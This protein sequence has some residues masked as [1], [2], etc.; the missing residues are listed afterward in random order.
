MLKS[1]E[2][3]VNINVLFGGF[4]FFFFVCLLFLGFVFKGFWLVLGLFF[5]FL[6]VT[7]SQL[8]WSYCKGAT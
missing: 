3:T 5:F 7:Q 4:I 6:T 1:T 2:L 8:A